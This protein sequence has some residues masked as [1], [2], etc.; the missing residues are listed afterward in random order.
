MEF[1]PKVSIVIPVY[2]GANFLREAIDSALAQTYQNIEII[3]VND[4][5]TDGGQTENIA[6]SYG[7]RIRYYYKEN[8]GVASALNFGI[9]EMRGEYF[10]WLSH[11]DVYYPQKVEA[12]VDYLKKINK[13]VILYSDYD[14]IDRESQY[15]RSEKIK[16]IDPRDFRYALI[17]GNPIHGCTTLVPRSCFEVVGTFDNRLKTVQDYDLWFRM[18]KKYDFMHLPQSLIK[19]RVHPEQGTAVLGSIHVKECN[20]YF[21]ACLNE[22]YE[23]MKTNGETLASF[24]MKIAI[25]LKKRHFDN[26][27]EHALRLSEKSRREN[28]KNIDIKY[29]LVRS[30]YEMYSWKIFFKNVSKKMKNTLKKKN[31]R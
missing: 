5:S 26:A 24:N 15:I 21:A 6:K 27:A 23:D 18:A 31:V 19:S 29:F 9:R 30:Y 1:N 10:S 4:G 20:N 12:Q 16:D 28:S 11:D 13:D 22:L 8:G 14:L 25:N 2:N 3:V 17:V 7:E